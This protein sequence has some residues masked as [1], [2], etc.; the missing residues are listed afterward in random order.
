MSSIYL[1]LLEMK[2]EDCPVLATV[3]GSTG[4]TPQKPGSSAIFDK[5]GLFA[6]TVGGGA[7]EGQ[8]TDY[9]LDSVH[10]GLSAL[11][12]F[13]LKNDISRKDLPICGGEITVLVDSKP[14]SNINAFR[15]MAA[16]LSA[17][18]PGVLL[19]MV[20]RNT[21]RSVL[22]NRYWVT[23]EK[24]PS[25]PDYFIKKL[26]PEVNS[27][28]S[29]GNRTGF[30][31]YDLAIPGEEPQSLFLLETI[32]PDPRLIIAGAGHIGRA[33][34][35]IGKLLDFEV[36]VIDDRAEYANK[37]NIPD[38]DHLVV[39]EIGKAVE[40][41]KKDRNTFIVIVTRGHSDDANALRPCIGS[42]AAYVGMIGS[43]PK[44]AQIKKEFIEK[45]YA[46]EEQWAAVHTP[47]GLPINSQ[48]VNEIAV[49]IAAQL[50]QVRNGNK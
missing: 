44:V 8:V 31:Q 23:Q 16:S 4:S 33:L 34:A 45:G 7:T 14:L 15:E 22:I 1:K 3:T 49:S 18:I 25:I 2:P 9:A 41:L 32:F 11:L 48:T 5:T 43:R 19:T 29:S 6:G 47:I 20:T 38:A 27:M 13:Q 30:R 40:S 37:E 12:H 42:G 46:T 50:V 17:G 21:E 26:M 28:I 10:T 36:T 24:F 35:H 39:E